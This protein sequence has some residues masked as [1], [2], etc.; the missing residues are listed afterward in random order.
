MAET[1]VSTVSRYL[2][3]KP[4]KE[5]NRIKI[6]KILANE[7]KDFTPNVYARALVS[8]TLKTV[9]VI[10]VDIRTPHYAK[11]CYNFEQIFT[12]KGYN[13]I[14]CNTS[15]DE[16]NLINYIANLKQRSVDG[17][18]FVGSIFTEINN[19]PKVLEMIKDLP[20]VIANG[21][22]NLPNAFSVLS[23]DIAGI[24]IA[25][26]YLLNKGRRHIHYLSDEKND[27]GMR[28]IFGF[29]KFC[30]KQGIDFNSHIE[31]VTQCI[32]GGTL[33]SKLILEK[34]KETDAIICGNDI[35]GVGVINYLHQN[36]IMPGK[37]ID[38]IAYNNTLY[39]EI[40]SPKMTIIDNKPDKQAYYLVDILEKLINKE[41]AES[42]VIRPELVIKESA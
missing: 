25:G 15:L 23:E 21:T 9:A 40:T 18:A 34:D 17:I 2:N 8:Q 36:G 37:D 6:E 31:Y 14:I 29:E 24:E 35:V 28:K 42:I 3:N 11:V 1:S 12:K 26:N 16:N 33:G 20:V 30:N 22:I 27:S 7:G 5:E 19:M 32:E 39:S 10:T 4:I 41:E 13:V 38:V